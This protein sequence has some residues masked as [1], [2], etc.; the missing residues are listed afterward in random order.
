MSSSVLRYAALRLVDSNVSATGVFMGTYEPLAYAGWPFRN[1]HGRL[2]TE[3]DPIEPGPAGGGAFDRRAIRHL[4][5]AVLGTDDI[6]GVVLVA[7][8]H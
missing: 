3:Q 7:V 5:E 6:D 4:E 2:L 8:R 1:E